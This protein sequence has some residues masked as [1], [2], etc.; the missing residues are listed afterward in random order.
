MVTSEQETQ[1]QDLAAVRGVSV[2]RLLTESALQTKPDL[3]TELLNAVNGLRRM[4]SDEKNPDVEQ[5]LRELL[6]R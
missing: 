4:I 1:L 2:A 3:H 6:N 5:V